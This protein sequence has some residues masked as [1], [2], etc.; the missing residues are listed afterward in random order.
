MKEGAILVNTARGALVDSHALAE[1]LEAGHL[2]GVGA[3]V[4]SPEPP[5]KDDELLNAPNTFLTPH[6]AAWNADVRVEMVELAL[7][8]LF[9]LFEGDVPSNVVNPEVFEKGLRS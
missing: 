3:D 9:L 2:A 5:P 4:F 1:L 7:S 8:S 6:V